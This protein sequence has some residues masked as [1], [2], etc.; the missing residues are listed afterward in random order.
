MAAAQEGSESG[1]QIDDFDLLEAKIDPK[2]L[3][4]MDK[5]S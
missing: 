3:R 5:V 1:Q 2:D 4:T